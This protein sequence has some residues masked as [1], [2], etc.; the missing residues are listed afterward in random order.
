VWTQSRH[1]DDAP[2]TSGLHLQT[3]I[4]KPGR[5]VRSV[6]I[7]LQSL[8]SKSAQILR[9]VG[10]AIDNYGDYLAKHKTHMRFL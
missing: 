8:F 5:L 1:F 9:A 10:A 6:P 7:L 2:I 4:V 3:D